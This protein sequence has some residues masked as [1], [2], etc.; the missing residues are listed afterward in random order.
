MFSGN[1]KFFKKAFAKL[2]QSEAWLSKDG[3]VWFMISLLKHFAL[4][5]LSRLRQTKK[6]N[7]FQNL[8]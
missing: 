5:Y 6:L 7:K 8:N 3:C 4:L 1:W 2:F